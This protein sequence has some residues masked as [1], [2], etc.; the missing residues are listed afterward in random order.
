MQFRIGNS[1]GTKGLFLSIHQL[2]VAE[3]RVESGTKGLFLS[4]H[5]LSVAEHRVESGTKGL[6][7]SIHQLSVAEH[8]VKMISEKVVGQAKEKLVCVHVPQKTW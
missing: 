2:S 6:F 5:Q 1:S 3:H 8:R 4:I 7:L